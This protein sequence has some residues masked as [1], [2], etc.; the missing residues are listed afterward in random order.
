MAGAGTGGHADSFVSG[1]AVGPNHIFL[2]F[3]PIRAGAIRPG[4][5]DTGSPG[6]GPPVASPIKSEQG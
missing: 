6:G 1:P 3:R 4:L 5:N 2:S